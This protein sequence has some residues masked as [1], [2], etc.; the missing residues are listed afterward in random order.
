MSQGTQ[1]YIS[2]L[3][4]TLAVDLMA[5]WALNLQLGVTGILNFGFIVSQAAGAYTAAMLTLGPPG[6]IIGFQDYLFGARLPFPLPLLGAGLAGAVVGLLIGVVVLRHL[7]REYQAIVMLVVSLAATSIA[8]NQIWLV[9]GA[10]GLVLIPKPLQSVLPVSSV[11]YQWL[12]AGFS[13]ALC[14]GV[15]LIMHRITRSPFGRTLRACRDNEAVIAATGRNPLKLQLIV[16]VVGGTVAGL[17]GA[18]LAQFL[19]A[20]GPYDWLYPATFFYLTAI[21]IGGSGNNWGVMVGVVVLSLVLHEG[22]RFLPRYGFA[23]F[24]EALSWV[25]VGVIMLLFLWFRPQGVIP[26]RTG[27][28]VTE[29]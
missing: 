12:Y 22:T 27:R 23:G 6:E 4:I 8:S 9:N 29:A 2:L 13:L 11:A 5:C 26:E 19:G 15:L 10:S 24:S 17:S 16:M 20:W 7:R 25:L 14:A 3:L 21:L 28:R 1:F 18:I